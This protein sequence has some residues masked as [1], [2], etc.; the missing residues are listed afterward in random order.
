MLITCS[1]QGPLLLWGGC[2]TYDEEK[3]L[4]SIAKCSYFQPNIYNL[5]SNGRVLLPRN[6]S[7]IVLTSLS[8]NFDASKI[9]RMKTFFKQFAA[10]IAVLL[11][12]KVR[13]AAKC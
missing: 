6:L 13:L 5:S 10:I 8:S 3:G 7:L 12:R 1:E 4:L 9:H 11:E 2:A